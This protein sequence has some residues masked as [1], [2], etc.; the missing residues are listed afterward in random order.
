MGLGPLTHLPLI[1]SASGC[2]HHVDISLDV[3]YY[4]LASLHIRALSTRPR[5]SLITLMDA[6]ACLLLILH[7]CLSV[8]LHQMHIHKYYMHLLH[9][10][11]THFLSHCPPPN[12]YCLG[13]S[14]APPFTVRSL[15]VFCKAAGRQGADEETLNRLLEALCTLQAEWSCCK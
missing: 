12:K 10:R 13:K 1:L 9:S 7:V 2:Y 3:K 8:S 11:V 5:S 15:I 14:P 6:L 4:R